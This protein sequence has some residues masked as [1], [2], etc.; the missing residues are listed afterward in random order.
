MTCSGGV[1]LQY[2]CH[3]TCDLQCTARNVYA[4]VIPLALCPSDAQLYTCTCTHT[5]YI[6]K[7]YTGCLTI[8]NVQF[9]SV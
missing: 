9:I 3:V 8:Y 7:M 5:F 4:S 1:G 6:V 2:G